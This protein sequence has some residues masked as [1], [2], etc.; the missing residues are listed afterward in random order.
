MN[1]ITLTLQEALLA[2]DEGLKAVETVQ[3]D[4]GYTVNVD[5]IIAHQVGCA[6][7]IAVCNYLKIPWN[8]HGFKSRLTGDAGSYEVRCARKGKALGM[9]LNQRDSSKADRKFVYVESIGDRTFKLI[10]WAYGREVMKD[11]YIFERPQFVE[12]IWRLPNK[13]LKPMESL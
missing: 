9:L 13:L 1:F 3:G 6:A 11:E 5:T 4:I 2:M 10:G 8:G 7:E 12:R